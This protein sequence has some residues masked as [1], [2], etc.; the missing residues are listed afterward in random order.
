M[1]NKEADVQG[2]ELFIG[3]TPF[4][5]GG[6]EWMK[7]T[8]AGNTWGNERKMSLSVPRSKKRTLEFNAIMCKQWNT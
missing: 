3:P 7:Q 1:R 4:G 5:E 6:G 2:R 8:T